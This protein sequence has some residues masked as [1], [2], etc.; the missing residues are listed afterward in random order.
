MIKV[1]D[2]VAVTSGEHKGKMGVV[3]YMDIDNIHVILK[4]SNLLVTEL[5]VED[6]NK[7]AGMK[8]ATASAIQ[9]EYQ[10]LLTTIQ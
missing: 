4:P 9:Q 1:G 10:Q 6:V 3:A 8:L 5:Y 7:V 2:T